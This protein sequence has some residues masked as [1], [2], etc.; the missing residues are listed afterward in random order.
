MKISYERLNHIIEEEVAKFK[1]LNE[2]STSSVGKGSLTD[3]Q[4]KDPVAISVAIQSLMKSKTA[5]DLLKIY[6]SLGGI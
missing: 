2:Q 3:D 6:S 5:T 1:G 4:K